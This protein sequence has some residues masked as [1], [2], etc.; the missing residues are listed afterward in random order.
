VT[1]GANVQLQS[2]E[3]AADL[4]A[5]V[6]V[7]TRHG[8]VSVGAYASLNLG[9]HVGDTPALVIENRQR[10]AHAFGVQLDDL[11][12]AEQIHGTLATTVDR[13]DRGRGARSM[14][15][16]VPASDILVTS[17]PGCVLVMLVADCVPMALIDPKARVLAV[18]HAGWRGTA[19]RVVQHA[20]NA[21]SRHGASPSDVVAYLGPAVHP[22]HYQVDDVVRDGLAR[23]VSPESLRPDV[24]IPD[25][26]GHWRVD[27]NAANRQQLEL[28]GVPEANVSDA[29]LTTADDDFFSDRAARPCGRFG[30]LAQLSP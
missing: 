9:L 3:R 18:V 19:G 16:A 2:W 1:T 10:A 14:D 27:L 26:D 11:I 5:S 7:T 4:G 25:G 17:D 28:A 23:A 13:S 20:L 6:S 24:A 30:L 29:G 8:G 15:D 21:M 12:F 22:D